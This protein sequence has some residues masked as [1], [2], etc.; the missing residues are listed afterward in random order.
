M[1]DRL[2]NIADLCPRNVRLLGMDVGKK[3]IGMALADSANGIVTPLK[4]LRRTKFT[5]DVR[6]IEKIVRDYEVGGFV[7]G[8]PLNMDG[9]EGRGCQSVRDFSLELK[10]QICACFTGGEGVWMAL[11]D[12]RLSTASVESFVDKSVDY[13]KRRAKEK[14]VTDALA[15]QVILQS[16]LDYMQQCS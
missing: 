4:T 15:A 5:S 2:E 7:I 3:T 16:A 12:E 8:Y 13:S 10:A 9:S 14:G 11:C 1:I 6:E